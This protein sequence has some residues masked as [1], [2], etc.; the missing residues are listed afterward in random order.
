MAGRKKNNYSVAERQSYKRGF[1]SGL[2]LS[3]KRISNKTHSSKKSKK[4]FG[5]LAFNDNCDVFNVKSYGFDREDALRNAKKHLKRDPELPCWG[6]TITKDKS[7][8]DYYRHVTVYNSGKV[9]DDW[10]PNYRA[11]DDDIRAKYKDLSQ[12]IKRR[13]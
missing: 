2:F 11:S 3:K 7:N 13:F 12:P 4:E 6:V 5:F 10:A 1:F 8:P 9:V